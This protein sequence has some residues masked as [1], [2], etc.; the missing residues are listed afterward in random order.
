MTVVE[1]TRPTTVHPEPITDP[2]D[3]TAPGRAFR[4][5]VPQE[6]AA[7][8]AQGALIVDIRR[9]TT[10]RTEGEIPGSLI[11][12]G[13]LREW[14]LDH[15]SPI[16]VASTGDDL[17]VI[18]IGDDSQSSILAA[19]ALRGLGVTH[20]TDVIGGFPAWRELGLPVSR[21]FTLAG[22]YVDASW[23]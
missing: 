8:Q 15:D 3:C 1:Q 19:S 10:R 14:R 5:L 9:A 2:A 11:V 17:T 16:R 22:R 23:S 6:A 18:A 21:G 12:A 13:P 7:A 20:A 4:R